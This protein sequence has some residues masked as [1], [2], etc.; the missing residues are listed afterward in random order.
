L[1]HR[2]Q[3]S[4]ALDVRY[5]R[6]ADY[7]TDHYLVVAKDRDRL[8]ASKQA[9]HNILTERFNLKELNK[10]EGKDSVRLL[11]QTDSQLWKT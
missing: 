4:S 2:R 8:V 11:S 7:D 1:I 6:R 5:F 3:N 10:A 9:M